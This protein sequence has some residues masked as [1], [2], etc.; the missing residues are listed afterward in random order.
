[1]LPPLLCDRNSHGTE[2]V[3]LELSLAFSWQ[4]PLGQ[5]AKGRS[6]HPRDCFVP[7][8]CI[9]SPF[10]TLRSMGRLANLLVAFFLLATFPGM[11][12]LLLLLLL[13]G[14]SVL[15]PCRFSHTSTLIRLFGAASV[16]LPSPSMHFCAQSHS[17]RS[18]WVQG[19]LLCEVISK[20]PLDTVQRI[21]RDRQH[22]GRDRPC[23]AFSVAGRAL[24]NWKSRQIVA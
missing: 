10:L 3:F 24:A 4:C 9:V 16:L 5:I 14:W 21:S 18:C 22:V 19:S 12:L 13:L 23:H 8:H 7:H 1:M 20:S 2:S 11:L 6:H 15:A 17:C